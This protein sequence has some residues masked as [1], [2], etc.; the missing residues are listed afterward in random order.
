MPT[1]DKSKRVVL[2]RKISRKVNM[3]TKLAAKKYSSMVTPVDRGVLV[4][5]KRVRAI[6]R[7]TN[8][9]KQSMEN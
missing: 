1:T 3:N 6:T 9:N 2:T 7:E 8:D 4:F 5:Y